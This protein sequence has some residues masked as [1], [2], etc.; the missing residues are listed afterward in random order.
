MQ[1]VQR[2]TPGSMRELQVPD[3]DPRAD[4]LHAGPQTQSVWEAIEGEFYDIRGV[5]GVR[6][7]ERS[8]GWLSWRT[9]YL[10]GVQVE[11]VC[12]GS[13][14]DCREWVF[15]DDLKHY[16]DSNK[17]CRRE[18]LRGGQI[19]NQ[20]HQ[21]ENVTGVT[22]SLQIDC[23]K[24]WWGLAPQPCKVRGYEQGQERCILIVWGQL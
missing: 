23:W 16:W 10:E 1:A 12:W 18:G 20:R 21:A 17:R 7:H 2:K 19:S 4:Q 6:I 22:G 24:V 3:E 15:G 5:D 11:S 13:R 14:E 9:Q 8:W